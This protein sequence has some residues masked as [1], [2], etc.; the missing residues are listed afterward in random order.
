[1]NYSQIILI[2]N[3]FL[4]TDLK[5]KPKFATYNDCKQMRIPDGSSVFTAEAKAIDLA[6]D[7]V[8]NCNNTKQ[9]CY[10]FF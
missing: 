5:K 2:T 9:V 1:M 3:I 8:K 7:F 4:P 10:F 6:L